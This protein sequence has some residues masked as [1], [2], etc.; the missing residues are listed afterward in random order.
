MPPRIDQSQAQ[1]L[2]DAG[3][4][5]VLPLERQGQEFGIDGNVWAVKSFAVRVLR[6]A[7]DACLSC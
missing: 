5:L 2:F 4:F 1:Q 3:G 7:G 6:S